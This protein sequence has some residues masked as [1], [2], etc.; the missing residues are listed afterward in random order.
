MDQLDWVALNRRSRPYGHREILARVGWAMALPLFRLS[1]RPLWGWRRLLLRLFGARVARGAR[2]Y[3]SVK[4]T[5]PWNLTFGENCAVGERAILYALG[6]IEIGARATVSQYAHLCAG[7]HDLRDPQRRL[8]RPPI[9][10]GEDVWVC[11]DAFIGP[12]VC[13]G[14]GA[15]AAARAVVMA[16]VA[17]GQIV[18]GNPATPRGASPKAQ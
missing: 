10:L 17:A 15:V 2:I 7:S 3:P 14:K 16:D 1:P 13:L 12:G 8:L 5:L 9:R 4:I 6:P 11:A 18:Q